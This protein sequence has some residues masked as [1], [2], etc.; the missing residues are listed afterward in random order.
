MNAAP[1]SLCAPIASWSQ[2]NR[3]HG[4]L[5]DAP[6]ST[7]AWGPR[8]DWGSAGWLQPLLHMH[9]NLV[10]WWL[11]TCN[12]EGTPYPLPP[13]S[14]TNHRPTSVPFW[15][16]WNSSNG[17]QWM[18][19]PP[20]WMPSDWMSHWYVK[21]RWCHLVIHIGVCRGCPLVKLSFFLLLWSL[22]CE[23][24]RWLTLYSILLFLFKILWN[25]L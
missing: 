22:K 1:H 15:L 14:Y 20:H 17:A 3:Q 4:P 7:I 8:P 25:T 21:G 11:E 23:N 6:H 24:S 18:V 2:T 10:M 13:F 9:P 5:P 16:I 19:G 12:N